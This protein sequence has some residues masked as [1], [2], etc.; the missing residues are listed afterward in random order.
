MPGRPCMRP[1]QIWR[2]KKPHSMHGAGRWEQFHCAYSRQRHIW[3]LSRCGHHAGSGGVPQS[4]SVQKSRPIRAAALPVGI[5][6]LVASGRQD[7]NLRHLAPK[8][9]ALPNCATPRLLA[10]VGGTGDQAPGCRSSASATPLRR[11]PSARP[12]PAPSIQSP[13]NPML[14]A[15]HHCSDVGSGWFKGCDAPQRITPR[16]LA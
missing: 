10:I 6:R 16:L 3:W 4:Q 7:S 2:T 12:N 14:L 8:A 13:Q 11:A 5:W 9:S 15:M 1:R